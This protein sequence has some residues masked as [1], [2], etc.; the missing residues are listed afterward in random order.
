MVGS[1][2]LYDVFDTNIA[3][4]ANTMITNYIIKFVQAKLCSDELLKTPSIIIVVSTK[5]HRAA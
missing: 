4:Y 3:R 2:Y 5:R 1:T